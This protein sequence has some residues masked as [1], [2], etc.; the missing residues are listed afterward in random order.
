MTASPPQ[1]LVIG[2][3]NADLTVQAPRIPRPGETVLGDHAQVS[4]GG[5]G[6]NQA[7]AAAQAG[8]QVTL[9]AA[10]GDDPFRAPS[11]AGL[12]AAGVNLDGLITAPAPTGLALI[13]VAGD[14]ENAITV[15]SGAN[16]HLAATHLPAD[17]QGVHTLLLQQELTPEITREAARR[18]HAAGVRVLL[19]AAP[20]RGADPELLAHTHHLIVNEHELAAVLPATAH[21]PRQAG[22]AD[23]AAA[24]RSL[25]APAGQGP[26]T[27]T[28]T[29]GAHG[30]VTVTAAHT[31]I[32]PALNVTVVD[33]TGAGDT[34]CGTL[35][36]RLAHG[37]DLERALAV[38]GAAAALA[39]TRPGAQAAMPALADTLALLDR[40]A[41]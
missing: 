20:D 6:A 35:A 22:S 8:A 13:T 10:V 3:V 15:A 41:R 1:V 37:E 11:L 30:S 27:V 21:L 38:A 28:V 18:A 36:A 7:V 17:F 24:A 14:G 39:C 9:I 26:D 23:I 4:P 40:P 31:H 2:S 12:Q 34:Y 33:T 25:L 5:K 29:L 16:L 19:N 32:Q